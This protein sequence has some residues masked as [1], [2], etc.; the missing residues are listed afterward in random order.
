MMNAKYL[1]ASLTPHSLYF[2]L[3]SHPYTLQLVLGRQKALSIKLLIK[4]A[5][6]IPRNDTRTLTTNVFNNHEY[7][8]NRTA[9]QLASHNE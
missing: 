4:L 7:T 9:K 1:L 3:A 2:Y 8:T 6:K 5:M